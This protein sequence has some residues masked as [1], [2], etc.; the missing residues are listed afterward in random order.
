MSTQHKNLDYDKQHGF[1][2]SITIDAPMDKVWSVLEDFNN[3]YSWAPGV[4]ES[5]GLGSKHQEIGASRY[6]KLSDFGTI[7]EVVTQWKQGEGFTYT[8][9]PLGPLNDAI[10]RWSLIEVNSKTTRLEV[11]FAYNIRFS[12]FGRMMHRLVMRKKLLSSLPDTLLALKKRIETGKLVRPLI[13]TQQ[14]ASTN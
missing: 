2:S 11:E 10:S 5:H 3:V 9:S 13:N 6:C 8:V 14:T 4:T 12:V 7:D 1:K